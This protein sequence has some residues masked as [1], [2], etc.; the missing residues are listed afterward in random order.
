MR[1]VR[2]EMKSWNESLR[3]E[4]MPQDP[5][6][7]S[8]WL[9]GNLPLDDAMKIQLLRID[10]AIQRLRCELNIM[11]RVSYSPS[12]KLMILVKYNKENLFHSLGK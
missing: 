4:M 8:Y 1:R 5:V 10:S 9:A 3:D 6:D 2:A 11:Q 7:F 12:E